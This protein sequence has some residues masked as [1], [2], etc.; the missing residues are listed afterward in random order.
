MHKY[1]DWELF[2][3]FICKATE[4]YMDELHVF[5]NSWSHGDWDALDK[6]WPEWVQFVKEKGK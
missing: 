4:E 3:R 2:G 6:E 5:I 1:E